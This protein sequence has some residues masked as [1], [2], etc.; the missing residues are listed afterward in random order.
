MA[1]VVVTPLSQINVRVGPGSPAA[2]QSTAQFVGASDQTAQIQRIYDVANSASATA[3][4]ALSQV[5][6]ASATANTALSQVGAT[7]LKANS[8]YASQNT[9]GVYANSAFTAANTAASDALAYA[10]ALG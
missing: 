1:T 3:N 8:A 4:T 7:F 2:V 10:I 9:T 6:A 5:G